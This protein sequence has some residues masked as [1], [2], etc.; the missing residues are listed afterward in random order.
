MTG[1]WERRAHGGLACH[2]RDDRDR[3]SVENS[4]RK[5]EE[6][7]RLGKKTIKKAYVHPEG[8]YASPRTPSS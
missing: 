4:G 2:G 5:L 1:A 6:V 7:I 3:E 8:R